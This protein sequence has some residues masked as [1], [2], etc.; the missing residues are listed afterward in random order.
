[1]RDG[2]ARVTL[3]DIAAWQR[4]VPRAFGRPLA[5]RL[6][7]VS[8]WCAFAGVIVACLWHMDFTPQRLWQGVWKLG[9]LMPL[10]FPP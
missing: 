10:M 8:G 5:A 1:M 9:W 7:V 6:G 4:A 2:P 3:A